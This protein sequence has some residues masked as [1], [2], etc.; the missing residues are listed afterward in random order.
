MN[1]LKRIIQL[2]RQLIDAYRF[3]KMADNRSESLDKNIPTL[4]KMSG[5]DIWETASES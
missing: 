4:F 1:K 5:Y 3:V 2:I